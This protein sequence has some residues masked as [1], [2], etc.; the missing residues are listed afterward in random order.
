MELRN[1]NGAVFG[2]VER[3]ENN[4]VKFHPDK[5]WVES[6]IGYSAYQLEEL[7]KYLRRIETWGKSNV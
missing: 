2:R 1:H 7:A 3:D 4:H 5:K 6:E